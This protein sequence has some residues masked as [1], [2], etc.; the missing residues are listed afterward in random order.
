MKENLGRNYDMYEIRK[1][2]DIC[3]KNRPTEHFNGYCGGLLWI[4]S[5][6]YKTIT[7]WRKSE[8]KE[9][10]FKIYKRRFK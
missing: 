3:K 1:G 9:K 7:K 4:C 2:C 8:L 10:K 5:E 6:C